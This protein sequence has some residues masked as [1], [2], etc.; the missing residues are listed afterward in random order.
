[1]RPS[2]L[3]TGLCRELFLP[4]APFCC[5]CRRPSG[6]HTCRRL[7]GR[8]APTPIGRPAAGG[9]IGAPH[10]SWP[11]PHDSAMLQR[12]CRQNGSRRGKMADRGRAMCAEERRGGAVSLGLCW[13]ALPLSAKRPPPTCVP[14]AACRDTC[15]GP[16][17]AQTCLMVPF[18]VWR[19][20]VT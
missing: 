19:P 3:I 12:G 14:G 15:E 17:P 7:G 20:G 8:P 9:P 2:L 13:G 16:T 1:M 6:K 11:P 18:D 4:W 5:T 10:G